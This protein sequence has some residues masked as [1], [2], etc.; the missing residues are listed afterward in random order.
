ML[1]SLAA[2][3]LGMLP[4]PGN[5]PH[6]DTSG[7]VSKPLPLVRLNLDLPP[8]ERWKELVAPYKEEFNAVKDYLE[9][10]VPKWALPIAELIAGDLPA[11][12]GDLG[13]EM[14]GAAEALEASKGLVVVMNLMMQLESLGLNCSNWN[15]TGPTVPDDPGCMAVDP[16]QEWCYCHDARA[17]GALPADG[18][19]RPP[20]REGPGLCTSIVAQT[21]EGRIVHARNLDW[22]LPMSLRELL[23]DVDFVR[24]GSVVAR[25]TGG[26]GF[27]GVYNGMVARDRDLDPAR[28]ASAGGNGAA[29]SGFSIT[30][31]ARGKGGKPWANLEQSLLHRSRTP[32]QLLRAVLEECADYACAV[33]ALSAGQLIDEN[34]YIVAGTRPGEGCVISRDRTKAADVWSLDA[35]DYTPPP[36]AS[37]RA[38]HLRP[39]PPRARIESTHTHPRA[40]ARPPFWRNVDPAPSERCVL[41][42]APL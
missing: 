24:N 29:S 26:A 9:Q 35:G 7:R 12:F 13:L 28:P 5:M 19:L 30:I 15:N 36:S 21:P 4:Q 34:Y 22:N 14:K 41:L 18:V 17:S 20:P 40:R 8:E 42:H 37:L 25:G 1:A 2:L 16:K 31:D 11:Y 38:P 6:P 32:S 39:P 3:T 33:A 23:W 27:V 10:S